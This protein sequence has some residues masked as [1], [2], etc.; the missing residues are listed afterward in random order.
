MLRPSGYYFRFAAP[1]D[2]RPRIGR[3]EIRKSLCTRDR[4]PALLMALD[5]W[6]GFS[7]TE[8]VSD[9]MDKEVTGRS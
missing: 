3:T 1:Y 7:G 8:A 5:D 9:A 4:R 6:V 2:L